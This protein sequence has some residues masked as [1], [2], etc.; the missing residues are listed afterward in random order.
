MGSCQLH[1]RK[2]FQAV[3]ED[4][5]VNVNDTRARQLFFLVG[6]YGTLRLCHHMAIWREGRHI[7]FECHRAEGCRNPA[8]VALHGSGKRP[9]ATDMWNV[10]YARH[11]EALGL[12]M[13]AN[14]QSKLT[15]KVFCHLYDKGGQSA[16]DVQTFFRLL[17]DYGG[18]D[19]AGGYQLTCGCTR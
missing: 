3:I 10:D 1:T 9:K 6:Y 7:W 11:A 15:R 14:R 2:R 18:D 5:L 4:G 12:T 13:D 16:V 17:T 8:A 19:P